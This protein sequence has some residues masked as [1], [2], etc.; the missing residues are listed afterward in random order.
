MFARDDDNRWTVGFDARKILRKDENGVFRA[1][2]HFYGREATDNAHGVTEAL[3]LLPQIVARRFSAVL[4]EWI[5]EVGMDKVIQRNRREEYPGVCHSHDFCDANMAMDGAL[6]DLG[7][8][9]E[10]G[11]EGMPLWINQLWNEAWEIAVESE[12]FW[13]VL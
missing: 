8:D 4:L 13:P 5:G 12:F 6:R 11:E 9:M 2:A 10:W 3:K 7:V 1:V